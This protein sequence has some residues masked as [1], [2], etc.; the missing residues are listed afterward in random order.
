[1]N[2][3]E[4]TTDT[5][6]EEA[7]AAL[8][9][10]TLPAPSLQPLPRG[11]SERI[12][13]ATDARPTFWERL[14]V[15]LRPAPVRFALGGAVTA[16]ALCAVFLPRLPKTEPTS[17]IRVAITTPTP[18]PIV[19]ASPEPVRNETAVPTPSPAPDAQEQATPLVASPAP[20]VIAPTPR[21]VV[22]GTDK[23]QAETVASWKRAG[24]VA[25]KEKAQIGFDPSHVSKSVAPMPEMSRPQ[26]AQ[27]V[28]RISVGG[29]TA[30][31][32]SETESTP[33]PAPAVVQ[34]ATQVA[35]APRIETTLVSGDIEDEKLK[36]TEEKPFQLALG[37]T[38]EQMKQEGKIGSLYSGT[39]GAESASRSS[40]N[41]GLLSAPVK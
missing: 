27:G 31:T 22:P 39:S 21:P 24:M 7:F 37:V 11:L 15:S 3:E 29:R 23:R 30:A 40:S 32:K 41:L 8:L 38:K 18:A 6:Q 9:A 10:K 12:A 26:G 34:P 19:P 1:M 2:P 13:A 33:T 28:A 35:R 20:V 25:L 5:L 36:V 16:A 14:T 4:I 17:P